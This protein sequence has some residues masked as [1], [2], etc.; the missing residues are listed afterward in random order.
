MNPYALLWKLAP[1]ALIL[2][3]GG[4]LWGSYGYIKNASTKL[5]VALEEKQ[6]SD[7]A[8]KEA[9]ERAAKDAR[10]LSEREVALAQAD[11]IINAQRRTIRGFKPQSPCLSLDEEYGWLNELLKV[12]PRHPESGLPEN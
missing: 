2:I 7:A 9:E 12:P 1:W 11:K 8:L 10:I 3:M 5:Q 6:R 4:T